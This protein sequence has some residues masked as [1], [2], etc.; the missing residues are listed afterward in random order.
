MRMS[1]DSLA[2]APVNLHGPM[3]K[4]FTGGVSNALEEE[5]NDWIVAHPNIYLE[6]QETDISHGL[7]VVTLWYTEDNNEYPSAGITKL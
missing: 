1:N 5:I 6:Q 3:C 4:I 7:F 2:N